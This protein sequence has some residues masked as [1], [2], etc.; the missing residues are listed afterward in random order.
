MKWVVANFKSN[1]TV[2]E[3]LQWIEK[4]GMAVDR[5][6]N[7]KIVLCPTLLSLYEAKRFIVENDYNLLLGAQNVSP[8]LPGAHTGEVAAKLLGKLVD[9]TLV[10]HSERRTEFGESFEMVDDKVK[11]LIECQITPLVCVQGTKTPIPQGVSLIAFEPVSAIGSGNPDTPENAAKVALF[12][13]EKYK[14][15]TGVLYGGSVNPDN[16][17]SFLDQE[18]LD[19]VLVGGASLEAEE[20][21]KIVESLI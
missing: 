12:F 14:R 1:K 11:R 16:A 17:K 13:K 18:S 10:G 20:F 9:L 6:R 8:Y 3:T 5:L 15:L 7:I 19:G 2:P 21:I 4:V